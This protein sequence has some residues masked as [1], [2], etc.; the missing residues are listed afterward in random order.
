MF[1]KS[2]SQIEPITS[3]QN[4]HFNQD[5]DGK[6]SDNIVETDENFWVDVENRE[7]LPPES[8]QNDSLQVA[9]NNLQISDEVGYYF[10]IVIYTIKIVLDL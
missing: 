8:F 6:K 5:V 4:T 10:T 9:M 3:I 2:E 1:D 7:I